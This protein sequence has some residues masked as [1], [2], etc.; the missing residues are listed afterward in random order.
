M[1][2]KGKKERGGGKKCKGL[3]IAF[4]PVSTRKKERE[5]DVSRGGRGTEKGEGRRSSFFLNTRKR[6]KRGEGLKG[7]EKLL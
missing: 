7:T 2:L 4:S 1:A 6:K 3:N 5:P